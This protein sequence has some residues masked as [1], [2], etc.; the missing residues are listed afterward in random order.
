MKMRKCP[1]CNNVVNAELKE[2]EFCGHQ[3]NSTEELVEE[4]SDCNVEVSEN[5]TTGKE[6]ENIVDESSKIIEENLDSSEQTLGTEEDTVESDVDRIPMDL[7]NQTE[8]DSREPELNKKKINM[9]KRKLCEIVG[10]VVLG[11][12]LICAISFNSKSHNFENKYQDTSKKLESLNKKYDELEKENEK[13]SSTIDELNGKIDELENGASKQLVGIKNAFEAGDWQKTIDLAK[14]LHEK[15]NGTPEDAEGQKLAQESQKKIN[16]KKAAEEA[17]KAKGYET[18]ITYSQLSRNPEQ[19]NG[20]KVK[21][22]G[23]V[24]QVIEG[25]GKEIQIRL[26]VNSDYDTILFGQYDSSIV[27]SRILEDDIITIYG[28]SVGTISYKSTMGG[29]ITIPGVAIE[30][31]ER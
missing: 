7:S 23:K 27:S 13:L 20:K 18:G 6:D 16:E 5:K 19:Y 25:D 30:K 22:K 21:F 3:F 14:T 11:I 26:A 10:G 1:K 12:S 29:T 8:K 2:C 24:V 15:Y 31:I 4:L 9:N 17:E 28:L